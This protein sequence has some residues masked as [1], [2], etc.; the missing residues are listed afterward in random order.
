MR[1]RWCRARESRVQTFG[2]AEGLD[3]RASEITPRG[4]QTTFRVL[5]SRVPIAACSRA[6]GRR[7]QRAQRAGGDCRRRRVRHRRSRRCAQGWRQFRGREAAARARRHAGATSSVY[8]DFAHHPT[9]VAETLAAVRAAEPDRR[10]WAIFE[11]RSASSC[12]RVF[13]DDFAR[14]FGGADEVVI[15][16]VFRSTPAGRRA[17]VRGRSWSPISRRRAWP[18][19]ICRTSTRSCARSPRRPARAIS[20]S[21]CRTAGS[22]AFTR[23]LLEAL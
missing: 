10:I 13:Q 1:R 15:A 3:W 23:K 17:A 19:G 16:S 7:A 18:R 9:A 14:A 4:Q 11:P 12:R 6:A 20:S 22:A 8:D 2:T 5:R 21:S